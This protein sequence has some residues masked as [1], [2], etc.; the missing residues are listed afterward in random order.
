MYKIAVLPGDG[1]GPE[2]TAEAVKVL[3][4][5]E[6]KFELQFHFQECLVGGIAY[7]ET[8]VPLPEETM[9]ACRAADAILLGAVG[10]PK[11][12]NLPGHLRPEQGALLKLR[13]EFELYANLR[14]IFTYP[15]LV[16][17]SPIKE[18]ILGN[19]VDMVILRELTGGLYFGRPK[20]RVPEGDGF[21][22]VDSMVYTSGEIERIVRLAFGMA[23]KRK[24]KLTS[25][26]KANV[27]ETSR[28]WR[29]TVDKISREYPAVEVNHMY[30]DNCTMQLILNPRQFDV[31]VAENTFG[32]IITDEASA[33]TGSIGMLP[34]ASI[35]EGRMALYEPIHGSAPDIA[36]QDKANPLATILSAA[37]M[38][39][40][41]F[42]LD[43]AAAG[44]E[45]AVARVLGKRYRT[46]D[47]AQPGTVIVGTREMGDK[48]CQE[49]EG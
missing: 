21:R 43:E 46:A 35:G 36:G 20:E 32:D 27:L 13:K 34:S 15:E 42:N 7:D 3:K 17:A 10:G 2:I 30:V 24:K 26:D 38:L 28:L 25:V 19:G 8:G 29:E 14:P 48:V 1:I 39:R 23:M 44:I 11:W 18:E 37:M 9:E 5:V 40:Y 47:I 31:V 4:T 45:S 41:S 22:A 49:L 6:S 33:L 16:H 12:D